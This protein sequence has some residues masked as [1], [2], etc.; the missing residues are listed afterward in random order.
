MLA[1][2]PAATPAVFCNTL[3]K[4]FTVFFVFELADSFPYRSCSFCIVISA[5][6][7]CHN[8]P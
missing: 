8:L 1:L 4:F 5:L 6:D 2:K 3:Q 7:G